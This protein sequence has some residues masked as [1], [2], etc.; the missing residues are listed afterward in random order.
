MFV[1]SPVVHHLRR[2]YFSRAATFSKAP[3]PPHS[4]FQPHKLRLIPHLITSILVHNLFPSHQKLVGWPVSA[5]VSR[6]IRQHVLGETITKAWRLRGNGRGTCKT[7]KR[8]L[9]ISRDSFT[10]EKVGWDEAGRPG[11]WER[12]SKG[13]Y[14]RVLCEATVAG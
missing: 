2:I 9:E 8:R 1:G 11:L 4:Q 3:T 14:S 5:D 7:N 13:S 12:S 10:V 6:R